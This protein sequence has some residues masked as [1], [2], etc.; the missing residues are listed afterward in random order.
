GLV[1][2][3]L[4][5]SNFDR[6][7]KN[8]RT[9]NGAV[10][11]I[12]DQRDRVI[13]SNR[14]EYQPLES[15]ENSA[16]VKSSKAQASRGTFALDAPDSSRGIGG[17]Y[18]VSHA[19]GKLTKWRVFVQQPLA[20]IHRQTERYYGMTLAWLLGAIGLSLLFARVIGGSITAPLE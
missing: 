11:L 15:M 18:L 1:V 10:I 8:Y 13:Y 12:L 2:G 20:E 5:L 17:G 4:K 19:E 3:S 16:L 14:G 9:L 6:F 7:D